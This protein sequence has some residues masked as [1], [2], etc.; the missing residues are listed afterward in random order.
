MFAIKIVL[1]I[2]TFHEPR[3]RLRIYYVLW[4]EMIG[5]IF[6]VVEL[7]I[8][9]HI[10]VLNYVHLVLRVIMYRVSQE[11]DIYSSLLHVV[12]RSNF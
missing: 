8:F 2:L 7:Y 12:Y 5:K 11:N 3:K 1:I 10:T 4:L 9:F 6:F